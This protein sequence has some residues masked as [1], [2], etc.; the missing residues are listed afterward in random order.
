MINSWDDGKALVFINGKQCQ[1]KFDNYYF[2]NNVIIKCQ[3][4]PA[5]CGGDELAN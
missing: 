5:A 3:E 1:Y 2:E 4:N